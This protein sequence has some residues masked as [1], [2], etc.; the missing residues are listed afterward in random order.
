[1]NLKP[2]GEG[3]PRTVEPLPVPIAWGIDVVHVPLGEALQALVRLTAQHPAGSFVG[4]WMPNDV[5]PLIN[6][7]DR[8]MRQARSGLIVPDGVLREEGEDE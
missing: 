3:R 7:L 1:M 6:A 4:F 2:N 5:P 8:A